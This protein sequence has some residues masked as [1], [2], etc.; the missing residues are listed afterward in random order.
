MD[1]TLSRLL[2]ALRH[3]DLRVSPAEA[4]DAF[5]AVHTSGFAERQLFKDALAIAVAKSAADKRTFDQVF[6][7]F[8][9]LPSPGALDDMGTDS[10]S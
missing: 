1:H 9:A 10:T 3:A 2:D 5:E 4:I 6:D 8:F 7:E